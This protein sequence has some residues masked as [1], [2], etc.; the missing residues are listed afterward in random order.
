MSQERFARRLEQRFL[1]WP[2]ED[3]LFHCEV[4]PEEKFRAVLKRQYEKAVV[5]LGVRGPRLPHS[6]RQQLRAGIP[7]VRNTPGFLRLE[8][9]VGKARWR[10]LV[11]R[12]RQKRG[13]A[14]LHLHNE[15]FRADLLSLAK[16]W[17]LETNYYLIT[18]QTFY[19][20]PRF[21]GRM[22]WDTVLL[23]MTVE[24]LMGPETEAG[25]R[26][27][28][29]QYAS[30]LDFVALEQRLRLLSA[31]MPIHRFHLEVRH[32]ARTHSLSPLWEHSIEALLLCGWLFVPLDDCRAVF[33]LESSR[34]RVLLEVF[35]ETR[36]GDLVAKWR[37]VEETWPELFPGQPRRRKSREQLGRDLPAKTALDSGQSVRQIVGKQ[38]LPSWRQLDHEI[39]AYRQAVKRLTRAQAKALGAATEP[40]VP[41]QVVAQMVC[42][43]WHRDEWY[44]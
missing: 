21:D 19:H 26:A 3:A 44:L 30:D 43:D 14:L 42:D 41:R 37:E 7:W 27:A 2:E 1:A 39:D 23:W 24:Y 22:V 5:S 9:R 36:Q 11:R 34:S 32:F 28:A 6:V 8:N 18:P 33:R 10:D 40:H 12:H 13:E 29:H 15:D 25:R 4:E 20:G 31:A 35:P 38:E 17:G 16:R